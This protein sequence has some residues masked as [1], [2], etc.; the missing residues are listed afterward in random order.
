[1]RKAILLPFALLALAL[2]AGAAAQIVPPGNSAAAQYT[3]TIPTSQGEQNA[4]GPK[5]QVNPN[6]VIGSKNTKK[7]EEQGPEGAAV[8]EFTAE[9]APTTGSG[10]EESSADGKAETENG[11]G[12]PKGSGGG[13]N[14]TGS[15]SKSQ[16][17]GG[18]E[19]STAGSGAAAGNG[20]GSGPSAGGPGPSGSSAV[21]EVAS[22]A[23]GVSSG[24]LGLWL[25]I[26]LV[27]VVLWA[28]LMV[29]RRREGPERAV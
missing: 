1:M 24:A 4:Q 29:W 3:E 13:G 15:G 6:D 10:G 16:E 22:Q 25:P 17:A 20:S 2:P 23:T 28:A 12:K 26:V 14:G 19:G 21:G 27:A 8:A 5:Q 18:E 11:G 9:T 7:L